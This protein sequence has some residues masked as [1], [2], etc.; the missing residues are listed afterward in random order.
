M[1]MHRD[2]VGQVPTCIG[3]PSWGEGGSR[4]C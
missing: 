1:H 2:K 4:L 3:I